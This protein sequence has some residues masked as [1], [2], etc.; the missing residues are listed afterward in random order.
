[1]LRLA[2]RL[3]VRP[4]SILIAALVT[5][6]LMA[7]SA[8]AQVPDDFCPVGTCGSGGQSIGG[9]DDPPDPPDDDPDVDVPPPS[10]GGS[11][12][13]SPPGQPGAAGSGSLSGTD[14]Q[15]SFGGSPR[16]QG[17][18]G[19]PGT[20]QPGRSGNPSP[21]P[22]VRTPASP[23]GRTIPSYAPPRPGSRTTSAQTSQASG[24]ELLPFDVIPSPFPTLEPS[25]SP[26]PS[27]SPTD[28][29]AAID[30]LDPDPVAEEGGSLI[31]LF[32][33]L[34]GAALLFVYFRSRN[35]TSRAGRVSG[36]R[37]R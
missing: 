4:L 8:G 6:G 22:A 2:V 23:G 26:S 7:T 24:A 35:R 15:D 36:A 5:L 16:D 31:P 32:A 3:R 9:D 17:R 25:P 12:S 37:Y 1:M 33:V 11:S 21:T 28:L 27:P 30:N 14:G 19:Q 13:G 34:V 20:G 18:A 29:V 10:G